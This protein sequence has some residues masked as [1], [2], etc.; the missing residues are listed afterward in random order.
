MSRNYELVK[1]LC[2]TNELPLPRDRQQRDTRRRLKKRMR[3][4]KSESSYIFK[5]V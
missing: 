3:A 4:R 5:S 2:D 1:K